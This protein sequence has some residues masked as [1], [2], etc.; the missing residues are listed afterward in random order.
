MVVEELS[1][2]KETARQIITKHLNMRKVCT[3]HFG[4]NQRTSRLLE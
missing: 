3:K 1:M 2:D 4:K